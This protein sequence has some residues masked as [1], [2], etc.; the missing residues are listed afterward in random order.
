MELEWDEASGSGTLIERNLDFADVAWFE[1]ETVR[2]VI[3][4]RRDYGEVRYNS[5]GYLEGRLCTFCWTP[6]N[7][8]VRVISLRKANARE[9]EEYETNKA[10]D[11]RRC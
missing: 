6:R 4:S 7:G 11:A 8:K 3:D 10:P 5:T 1:P 2:T 9:R